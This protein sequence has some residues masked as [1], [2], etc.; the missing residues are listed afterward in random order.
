MN[1]YFL[2]TVIFAFALLFVS[3]PLFA[4]GS[5]EKLDNGISVSGT[6]IVSIKP[7]A[8]SISFAVITRNAQ[9]ATA[10]QQNAQRMAAVIDAL[11][12]S[13]ITDDDIAT[14]NFS[15][16][17]ETKH[18]RDGNVTSKEFRVTNNL[19]VTVYDI[20]K[21]GAIIDSA[22]LAGANQF[23][24]VSFFVQDTA[25]AYTQARKLAV[26]NATDAAQTLALAAGCKLGKPTAITEQSNNSAYRSNAEF[27]PTMLT[28]S[29]VITTPIATGTT[30]ITVLVN[31]H[32]TIK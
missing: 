5:H 27:Q 4:L 18:D 16:Y 26:K 22:L 15:V 32:F 29:A 31:M 6:G 12:K 11:K 24:S 23:S 14:Q 1:K 30:N 2:H 28:K 13:S 20:K 17:Q 19:T 3:I 8:A 21:V 7:D 10:T 25:S 9:V